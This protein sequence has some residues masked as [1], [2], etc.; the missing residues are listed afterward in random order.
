[1][2]LT[3]VAIILGIS[4]IAIPN[5]LRGRAAGNES[6]VVGSIR[7]INAGMVTYNSVTRLSALEYPDRIWSE[8]TFLHGGIG[9]CVPD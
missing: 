3:V 5:L 1:M 6:S 4:A 7:T 9:Q 2:L 8:R